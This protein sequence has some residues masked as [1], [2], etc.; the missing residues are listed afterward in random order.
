METETMTFKQQAE[1]F[2]TQAATR[3]RDPIRPATLGVYRS[4][5]DRHL[6][7]ALGS[8]PLADVDNG[9]LRPVVQALA[10]KYAAQTV[11][12]AVG[13]VKAVVKSAVDAN[14]NQLYPR[15]WNNDFLDVPLISKKDQVAPVIPPPSIE[16]ALRQANAQDRA[17]YALLAGTGLRIAEA[18]SLMVGPDD[19]QHSYWDPK[20]GTLTVRTTVSK[21]DIQFD[22]KTE[23]G[24]RQ[25]DLAPELNSFLCSLVLDGKLPRFGLLFQGPHG[26]LTVTSTL[27]RRAQKA[28]V[29]GFHSF[30]RFRVTHLRNAGVP[31]GIIRFWIGHAD[32][33]ITD[34]YDKSSQD[35]EAR[36]TWA[37]RAGLGFALEAA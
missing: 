15:T 7:P 9:T 37:K 13:L 11:Q 8:L 31:D 14:G 32:K 6:L 3:R 10:A 30:R 17:L 35:L 23:A 24:N 21:Q 27:R 12:I 22:T 2:M 26:D 5:L 25:V 28:A 4:M 33:S 16:R 29:P 18:Q 1:T 34:R 36:K 20:T 19:G